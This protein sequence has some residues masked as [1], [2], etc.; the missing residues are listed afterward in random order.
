MA[1]HIN[2]LDGG[3]ITITTGG[4]T[5]AGHEET[6]YKYAGD[7]EW[8]TVS[9]QGSIIGSYDEN[10]GENIPTTQIPNVT[11]VVELEIGTDVTSIGDSA[12]LYCDKL[13]SVTIPNRV[14]SIGNYVFQGCSGL[15]SITIPN[16]VTSIGN[17]A[18]S[19]C[20]GL[21]SV[22]IGNGVTNIAS[23]AFSSCTG[24]TNVTIGDS[25]ESIGDLAFVGCS[26]LT[27]VTFLGKSIGQVRGMDN[28]PWGLDESIINA[29]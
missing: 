15:T 9:I 6:W 2:K 13:T 20:S 12:F 21:T 19:Y 22:T 24:L 8:R 16:S 27:N 23:Y 3:N 25:V 4:S 11:N 26:G 10:T 14:L 28:Y 5:P 1:I 7:T 17:G 29:A 18:F